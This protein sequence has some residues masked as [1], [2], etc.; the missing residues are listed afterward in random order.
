[1]SR[2]DEATAAIPPVRVEAVNH[3][4]VADGESPFSFVPKPVERVV[5]E[6]ASCIA[7]EFI[8]GS[9]KQDPGSQVSETNEPG[10]FLVREASPVGRQI[11]PKIFF[12][13]R[14]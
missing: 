3:V 1:M 2:T 5:V 4:G 11:F 9:E 12:E 8:K 10:K 7:R 6:T 14:V 13:A